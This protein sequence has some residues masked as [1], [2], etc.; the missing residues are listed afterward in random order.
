MRPW[1]RT[2]SFQ[3]NRVCA[4]LGM[5]ISCR[6]DDG[7][8]AAAFLNLVNTVSTASWPLEQS[9]NCLEHGNSVHTG[10]S[11][12]FIKRMFI[13]S[14]GRYK[15]SLLPFDAS[16][17]LN[18]TTVTDEGTREFLASG[19]GVL[20]HVGFGKTGGRH[21]GSQNKNSNYSTVLHGIMNRETFVQ[22]LLKTR[23]LMIGFFK[24]N[25]TPLHLPSIY[26]TSRGIPFGSKYP[27]FSS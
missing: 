23:G 15:C 10:S 6:L 20:Q 18:I 8:T 21:G 14:D 26:K 5:Y 2:T 4:N 1:G 17:S 22:N 25:F 19:Y 13:C 27:I 3:T 16:S 12:G 11:G 24:C 7:R 9:D